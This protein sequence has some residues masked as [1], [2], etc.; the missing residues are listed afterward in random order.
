MLCWRRR[1]TM[2]NQPPLGAEVGL[3]RV[4][5][6]WCKLYYCAKL[7]NFAIY[8]LIRQQSTSVLSVQ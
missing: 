2:L 3:V 6:A 1:K 4:S 7:G 8:N 5:L